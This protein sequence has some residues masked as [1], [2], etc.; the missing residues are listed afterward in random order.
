MRVYILKKEREEEHRVPGK[1]VKM[2]LKSRGAIL[3]GYL[4][5]ET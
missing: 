5:F 2:Q 3:T 4:L 1:E